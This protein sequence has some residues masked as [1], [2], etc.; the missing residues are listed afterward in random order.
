MK[1]SL[2]NLAGRIAEKPCGGFSQHS[3]SRPVMQHFMLFYASAQDALILKTKKSIKLWRVDLSG[4]I[5]YIV[6]LKLAIVSY[7]FFSVAFVSAKTKKMLGFNFIYLFL[8][9]YKLFKFYK[10]LS[11]M[12]FIPSMLE[13]SSWKTVFILQCIFTLRITQA[14]VYTQIITYTKRHRQAYKQRLTGDC[15]YSVLFK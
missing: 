4:Y 10:D 3:S 14:H 7:S 2:H 5:F 6:A 13:V 12:E 15:F 9:Y 1:C 11:G 8:Q